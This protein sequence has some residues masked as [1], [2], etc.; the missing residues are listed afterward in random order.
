MGALCLSAAGSGTLCPGPAGVVVLAASGPTGSGAHSVRGFGCECRAFCATWGAWSSWV[1]RRLELLLQDNSPNSPRVYLFSLF[2]F[3]KFLLLKPATP[4]KCL[5][6]HTAPF[7]NQTGDYP[8]QG[9]SWPNSQL[10]PASVHSLRGCSQPL[11][12]CHFVVTP[13][14]VTSSNQVSPG[15]SQTLFGRG[16]SC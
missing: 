1:G 8:G 4:Y 3:E 14:P 5:I 9:P 16:G 7:S 6:S 15:S 10:S 11:C 2:L 13:L 12:V